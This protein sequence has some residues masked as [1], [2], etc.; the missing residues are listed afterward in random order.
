LVY[1]V[2]GFTLPVQKL[3]LFVGALSVVVGAI[4][5][6]TQEDFKRMLAYSSI[7]QVGYIVLGLG[8]ASPLGIAAAAFHF[9]NHAVFKS[10]L[11]VNS[12]TVE[13][14]AGTRDMNKL[15]GL[16]QKMPVTG[17]TSALAALSISGVPPLAG[18]WS[19]LFIIIALWGAGHYNYAMI[20]VLASLLTLAYMLIMQRKVFF[21][22]ISEHLFPIK[23]GN[24]NLV[25]SS[26]ILAAI[27]V[28]VG[29]LFPFS[30]CRLLIR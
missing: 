13:K 20:A 27:T 9:F 1:S 26:I 4:A 3:L 14:Q 5:T 22:R 10:L 6:L 24:W 17:T 21:G 12:A 8:A 11:F 29:I 19:K 2:F 23:E 16:A 28:G 25:A 30:L 15:V 18:F 7:S